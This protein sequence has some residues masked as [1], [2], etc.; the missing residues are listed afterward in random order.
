LYDVAKI[1]KILTEYEYKVTPFPNI[2]DNEFYKK[3]ESFREAGFPLDAIAE[4]YRMREQI[5]ARL[6][7]ASHLR[8]KYQNLMYDIHKYME[9]IRELFEKPEELDSLYKQYVFPYF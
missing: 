9:K 4:L 1:K 2:A 8:T 5:A 7:F 3:L 6:L